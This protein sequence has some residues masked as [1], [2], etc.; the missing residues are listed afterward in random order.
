MNNQTETLSK[1]EKQKVPSYSLFLLVPVLPTIIGVGTMIHYNIPT[2][3]WLLNLSIV[4]I[5]S[6]ITPYISK[7]S[8]F[9]KNRHPLLILVITIICLLSTFYNEGIMDVHRWINLKSFQ[10]NIGLILSPIILIQISRIQNLLYYITFGILTTIIFLLQPDA[11]LVTAFSISTLVLLFSKT[12][13]KIIIISYLLF[14]IFSVVF[15]WNNLDNLQPVSY[16]ESIIYLTRDISSILFVVSIVTLVFLILPFIKNF[17]EKDKLSLS[18]GIYFIILIG[19]TFFGNF[20][21][22]F[23]GY[24]ISPIIGY[25]SALIWK[26][27]TANKYQILE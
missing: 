2:K 11:S 3:I 18:L 7:K 26:I 5:G 1:I 8:N 20:P 24:G 9:L 21:V 19:S 6:L 13:S 25:Y 4:C 23:M 14:S 10:I 12:K 22:M 16:V 15:T 17:A 27:S